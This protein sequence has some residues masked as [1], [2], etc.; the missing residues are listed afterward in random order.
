MLPLDA[1]TLVEECH[2]S[3]DE[4]DD[5]GR[6]PIHIAAMSGQPA[7]LGYLITTLSKSLNHDFVSSRFISLLNELE[8]F[9]AGPETGE[10]MGD[11]SDRNGHTGSEVASLLRV[12]GMKFGGNLEHQRQ[13]RLFTQVSGAA[14]ANYLDL[15]HWTPLHYAS[16]EQAINDYS[17]CIGLLLNHG[18]DPMMRTLNG[19][20]ALDLAYEAGRSKVLIDALPT[21]KMLTLLMRIDDVVPR[22]IRLQHWHV[23]EQVRRNRSRTEVSKST[24]HASNTTQ[25]STTLKLPGKSDPA[26]VAKLAHPSCS[27]PT[28]SSTSADSEELVAPIMS[29]PLGQRLDMLVYGRSFISRTHKSPASGGPFKLPAEREKRKPAATASRP[30]HG[31]T[32][33]DSMDILVIWRKILLNDDVELLEALR[34][35]MIWRE[36]ASESSLQS[37]LDASTQPARPASVI[38]HE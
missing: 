27:V 17:C 6:L 30:S 11:A 34:D 38:R 22:H 28:R 9:L 18:A 16:S 31:E 7:V 2:T 33:L 19:K 15:H 14:A 25:A 13:L 32:Q 5:S 24:G 21:S 23:K 36:G 20:T 37:T 35:S 26:I 4:P 29:S 3:L 12:G 10:T 8:A 1:N